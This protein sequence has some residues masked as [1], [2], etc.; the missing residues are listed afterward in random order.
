MRRDYALCQVRSLAVCIPS[1]VLFAPTEGGGVIDSG[2]LI[3]GVS[4]LNRLIGNSFIGLFI[5]VSLLC[6]F[7]TREEVKL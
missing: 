6:I 5:W 1:G 7:R 3:V 4:M 2:I